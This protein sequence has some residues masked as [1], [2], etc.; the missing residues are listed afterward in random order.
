MP[1]DRQAKQDC[2]PGR[3]RLAKHA[4][5]MAPHG[6][7]LLGDNLSSPQ[8][9]CAVVFPR[10]CN[11]ILTDTPDSHPTLYE[12]LACWQATDDSSVREERRWN[13]RFTE[14][15]MVRDLNEVLL[16]SGANTLSV[17]WFDSTVVNTKTA[18]T[19]ITIA[20]SPGLA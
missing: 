4:A 20:G 9:F 17:N 10:R 8:P 2:E 12:R 18:N 11:C 14:V 7:T 5:Q 3:Q 19:C 6:V 13:G 15:T 16:C 1:Q